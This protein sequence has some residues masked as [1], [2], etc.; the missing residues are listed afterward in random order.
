MAPPSPGRARTHRRGSPPS[1]QYKPTRAQWVR[2]VSPVPLAMLRFISP[3]KML[4]GPAWLPMRY[5]RAASS[6]ERGRCRAGCAGLCPWGALLLPLLPRPCRNF[7]RE[8]VESLKRR[9]SGSDSFAQ[10]SANRAYRLWRPGRGGV[11]LRA[12]RGLLWQHIACRPSIGSGWS[13]FAPVS[14]P[15]PVAFDLSL[16][17]VAM[18][19]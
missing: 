11:G 17:V 10:A 16:T 6:T 13:H 12:P 7:P 1:I 3:G 18:W 5:S 15:L 19:R 2:K 9:A 4:H 8:I 14:A